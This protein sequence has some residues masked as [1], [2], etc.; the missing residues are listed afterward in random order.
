MKTYRVERVGDRVVADVIEGEQERALPHV[1]VHSP[2]GFEMGYGGSG[3]ADLALSILCE[4]FDVQPRNGKLF[5]E[6]VEE[7]SAADRAWKLHQA[8][9]CDVVANHRDRFTLGQ[10]AL[11]AW[12]ERVETEIP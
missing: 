8:L 12:V 10:A 4:H 11:E 9:K 2:G 5:W 3:P 7:G 6:R 1:V